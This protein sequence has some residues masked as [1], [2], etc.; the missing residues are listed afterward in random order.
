PAPRPTPAPPAQAALLPP[1]QPAAPFP[2]GAKIG[3]V[4]LQ[5]I[6]AVS[7]DGK[8]ATSKVNA[9]VQKKQNE[10]GAKQKALQDNQTKL[11]Q[12][13]AL[14]SEAARVQLQKE[15]ER[16]NVEVQRMQQDA[17]AEINELQ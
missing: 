1:V 14:M 9:L 17:Q 15:I 8:V 16:L 11:E 13:G 10:L 2:Q 7:A 6:A 3:L 4:N 12:S 5:Q